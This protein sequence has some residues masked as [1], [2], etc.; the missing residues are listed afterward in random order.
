MTNSR[1]LKF[2]ALFWLSALFLVWPI[3][4]TIALRNLLLLGGFAAWVVFARNDVRNMIALPSVRRPLLWLGM[5]S[6]W[7]LIQAVVFAAFPARTW[8]ELRAQWLTPLIALATGLIVGYCGKTE[9]AGFDQRELLITIT[10]VLLAQVTFT[11]LDSVVYWIGHGTLPFQQTRLTNTKAD[12][13]FLNNIVLTLLCADLLSRLNK[14][15]QLL[16][17]GLT[18]PIIGLALSLFC[19]YQLGARNGVIGVAFLTLSCAGLYLYDH[20]G[21]LTARATGFALLIAAVLVVALGWLS[22][23]SDPRWLA[24][25]E[26]VPIALDTEHHKAW[27][28]DQEPFP[29]MPNGARVDISAYLRIAWFKEGLLLVKENPLGIGYDRKAFSAALRLKYEDLSLIF[30]H[31]HSGWLDWAIG[32]GIPGTLLLLGF[33]ASLVRAG[34]LA[35]YAYRSPYGL[36]LVFMV[37]GFASRMV[38]DG[39]NHDHSL[40]QFMFLIGLLLPMLHP[41][42]AARPTAEGTRRD[43]GGKDGSEGAAGGNDAQLRT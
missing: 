36:V 38:V 24:F 3:P 23:K 42:D 35:Y 12:M 13:S 32:T 41:G 17:F 1:I 7:L 11:V 10:A 6:A 40:Q 2:G 30:E 21:R 27:R 37:T 19:T 9:K 14:K 15:G 25:S 34:G 20:R 31:S 8:E 22:Y 26:T 43:P 33:F 28:D 18:V 16:R 5:I 39:N 4:H 29:V